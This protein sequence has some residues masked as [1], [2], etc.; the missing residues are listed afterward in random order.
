VCEKQRRTACIGDQSQLQHPSS[1]PQIDIVIRDG[2]RR[3]A[4]HRLAEGNAVRTLVVVAKTL[5]YGSVDPVAGSRHGAWWQKRLPN[6]RLEVVPGAG[7]L[8]I[9]PMWART[10][11]HLA[12][13]SNPQ[14]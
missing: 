1:A 3:V 9:L 11:S 4:V 12:P 8:L 13:G 5:L 6:A 10:L 2:S 7:H 14:A